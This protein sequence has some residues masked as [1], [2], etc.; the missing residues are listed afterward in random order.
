[1]LNSRV[2]INNVENCSNTYRKYLDQIG[3]V[4]I[5]DD[6]SI[7]GTTSYGIAFINDE[8]LHQD[9]YQECKINKMMPL[10]PHIVYFK[11]ENL[12]SK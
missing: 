12:V 6:L 7:K 10:K 8:S 1:M 4:R 2:M 5:V 9:Y 3:T 11:E